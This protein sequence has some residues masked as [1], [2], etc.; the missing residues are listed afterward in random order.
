MSESQWRKDLNDKG[1]TR[2]VVDISKET[3]KK[4][5]VFSSINNESMRKVVNDALDFYIFAK[6]AQEEEKKKGIKK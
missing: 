1:M 5:K 3:K 2:L 6:N 4:A